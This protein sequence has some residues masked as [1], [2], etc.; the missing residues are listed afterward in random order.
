MRKTLK[1]RNKELVIECNAAS[2]I[3]HKRI[4]GENLM[5]NLQ[6]M[7]A[8]NPMESI[9][10]IQRAVYTFYVT[11]M[12]GVKEALNANKDDFVDFLSDFEMMEFADPDIL[13]Q[14]IEAWGINIHSE[15][16]PKNQEGPQQ[17]NQP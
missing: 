2:P 9:E 4:W 5:I 16:E 14:I 11:A 10:F 13:D 15:S 12:C 8:S 17:E 6:K 1:M 3:I 7:D